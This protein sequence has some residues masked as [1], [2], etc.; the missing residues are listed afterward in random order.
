M[1]K[2]I[3]AQILIFILTTLL[4]IAFLIFLICCIPCAIIECIRKAY[5]ED[6]A[7]LRMH[8]RIDDHLRKSRDDHEYHQIHAW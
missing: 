5:A 3:L 2:R 8:R 6:R 1:I 7:T 4:W